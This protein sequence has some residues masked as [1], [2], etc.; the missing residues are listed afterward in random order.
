LAILQ[1]PE[2]LLGVETPQP[3]GEDMKPDVIACIRYYN[4]DRLHSANGDLSPVRHENQ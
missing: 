3:T 2:T 1:Q 4:L